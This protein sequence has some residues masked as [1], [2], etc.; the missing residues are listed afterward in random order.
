MHSD[1]I[2]I[3]EGLGQSVLQERETKD[4]HCIHSDQGCSHIPDL[5]LRSIHSWGISSSSSSSTCCPYSMLQRICVFFLC[6]I[7]TIVFHLY[8]PKNCSLCWCFL[9]DKNCCGWE[10][11]WSFLFAFVLEYVLTSFVICA[12]CYHQEF[13]V[14][15][16]VLT[17]G[18]AHSK[19]L[20]GGFFWYVFLWFL[21]CWRYLKHLLA[22][23]FFTEFFDFLWFCAGVM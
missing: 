20:S 15:K 21:L 16:D 17:C 5:T 23:A 1:L 22:L 2:C 6:F 7:I 3:W 9:L 19:L 14:S 11:F 8:D 4:I 12:L 13:F 10:F 18:F